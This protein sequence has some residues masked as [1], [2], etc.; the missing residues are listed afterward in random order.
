VAVLLRDERTTFAI[1]T[2]PE[3][4]PA[5]E[6]RFL[7]E[8]LAASGMEIGELIVNRVHEHGLEG[9]S[10]ED[11][12]RLLAPALGGGLAGRVASNLEDY[13][14][15]VRGDGET[16]ERLA[17][18]LGGREPIVIPQLDEDV[19]DLLVLDKIAEHLFA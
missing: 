6:A 18:M 19:Q 2:S 8:Q 16:I 14:V 10:S 4:E 11:V 13:D 1:V 7:A 9:H 5:R 17:G 15:L 12:A 3:A